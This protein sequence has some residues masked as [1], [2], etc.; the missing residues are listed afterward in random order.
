[1]VEGDL[2]SDGLAAHAGTGD[3]LTLALAR[4]LSEGSEVS[5]ES[6][7]ALFAGARQSTAEA[8]A[9]LRPDDFAPEEAEA[10]PPFGD[11]LV[12]ALP[13][14][15]GTPPVAKAPAVA[16]TNG[17]RPHVLA[18]DEDDDAESTVRRPEQL[19]LF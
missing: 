7:E 13:T 2:A 6:L 3:D 19:R 15:S 12:A 9:A 5:E 16:R 1:V 10:A 4:S 17:A 11:E 18:V 8:E 14:Y